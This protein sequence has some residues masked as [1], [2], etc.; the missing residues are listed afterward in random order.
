MG[1]TAAL[2]MA[3]STKGRQ[4]EEETSTFLWPQEFIRGTGAVVWYVP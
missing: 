2:K 3:G 4:G 1:E